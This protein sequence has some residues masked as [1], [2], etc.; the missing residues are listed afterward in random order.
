MPYKIGCDCECC[1]EFREDMF[2]EFAERVEFALD[3]FGIVPPV[4]DLEV[5]GGA[6]F[7]ACIA[8]DMMIA[9]GLSEDTEPHTDE[10]EAA[11]T[12]NQ[13]AD[14]REQKKFAAEIE[15]EYR[16]LYKPRDN[17]VPFKRK[18]GTK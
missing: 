4:P 1:T 6:D 13:S 8:T 9:A 16:R 5:A 3:V 12:W 2:A 18:S 10:Q 7:V 17:V 14:E 15:S 11:L